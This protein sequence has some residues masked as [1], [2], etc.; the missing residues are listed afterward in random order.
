MAAK[1]YHFVG[2]HA[3]TVYKGDK[4]IPVGHGME[5]ISLT[6]DDLN[7]PRNEGV[8]DQF[9]SVQEVKEEVAEAKEQIKKGG[10]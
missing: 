3:D 8:K 10:E 7:D 5:P 6:D 1:K 4:A 9:V 2:L